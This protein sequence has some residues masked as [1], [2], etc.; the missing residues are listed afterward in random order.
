MF[1]DEKKKEA[2]AT[3][4]KK[5]INKIFMTLKGHQTIEYEMGKRIFLYFR[6]RP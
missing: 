3:L 4:I 2:K 5:N 6:V 1:E